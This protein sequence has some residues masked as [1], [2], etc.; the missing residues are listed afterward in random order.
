MYGSLCSSSSRLKYWPAQEE[1]SF[2]VGC[3]KYW[4]S[5]EYEWLMSS[6][7]CT[8]E[9]LGEMS[10]PSS[11]HVGDPVKVVPMYA[12]IQS[13]DGCLCLPCIGVETESF[14][15]QHPVLLCNFCC[16]CFPGYFFTEIFVHVLHCE[17][18]VGGDTL[19]IKAMISHRW[20]DSSL[21]WCTCLG[22]QDSTLHDWSRQRPS[23]T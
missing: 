12:P 10:K 15:V 3:M 22:L 18:D 13:L 6:M 19:L 9:T 23:L 4:H 2:L 1:S 21:F 20:H 7:P 5:P 14:P 11:G 16:M 17:P 8:S